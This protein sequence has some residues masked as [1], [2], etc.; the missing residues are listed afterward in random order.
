MNKA[1]NSCNWP[2][3]PAIVVLFFIIGISVVR[4]LWYYTRLIPILNNYPYNS[5]NS[6]VFSFFCRLLIIIFIFVFFR[7]GY[8]V[9]IIEVFNMKRAQILPILKLCGSLAV[10]NIS[11]IYLLDL[12]LLLNPTESTL[13]YIESMDTKHIALFLISVILIGPIA[14]EAFRG[15]L[16]SPLYRKVGRRF[17]IILTSLIWSYLHFEYLYPSIEVVSI[18]WISIVG[19]FLTWLYDRSG[20]LLHPIIFHIFINSWIVFYI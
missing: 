2:L 19:V 16:Y 6:D 18:F 9:S 7:Y 14:E 5:F 20:S 12:N 1:F 13:E 17:S 10:L 3:F 15:L 8:K 11:S 4:S